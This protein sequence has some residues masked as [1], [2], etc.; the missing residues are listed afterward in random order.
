MAVPEVREEVLREVVERLAPIDR[1]PC[2][3][4]EREAA[5]WIAARLEK[6]GAEVALEGEPGWGTF[7][8][9][10]VGLG[11][12]ATAAA[13]LTSRGRRASGGALAAL[14]LAGLVDE[15]Q[16]G[17]RILRRLVRRRRTTTNVVASLGDRGAP[18]TL[19]VLAHHDA[20]Q[21]GVIFDQRLW[22]ALYERFPERV[23]RAKRQV[24]LWWPGLAPPLLTLAAAL[25]ARRGLARAALVPA[26]LGTAAVADIMRH[27]TV[28]GANDNLSGVAALVALA[29]ML[30]ERPIDGLRVL[31]VSCGSEEALQDGVRGFVRSHAHEL[32]VGRTWF[33]V[34]DTIGSPHLVMV[35][36]EGPVWHEEYPGPEF[37]DLVERRAVAL[38]I[39]L[40]RGIRTRASTDGI[41]PS[42]AGHPVATLVSLMPW[43]QPGNYHQMSDVPENVEYGSVANAA[44]LTCAVAESLA[45][46]AAE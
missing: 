32:E 36:G 14:T 40:E 41:I 34:V 5:E 2:S 10:I 8:P 42:R 4:G 46:G 38:G 25:T 31:L 37:R 26:V 45:E 15:I 39:P 30:A 27:A 28:P 33:V 24:P 44:R 12:A 1:A 6:T 29:E 35:E 20:A 17:P 23:G 11:V 7:P 21:A 16:N 9:T 22:Q 19:V 3:P 13:L 43:R 18:R